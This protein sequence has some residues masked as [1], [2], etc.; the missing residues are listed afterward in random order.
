MEI[1]TINPIGLRCRILAVF[2]KR[3][4]FF[5]NKRYTWIREQSQYRRIEF[6]PFNTSMNDNDEKRISQL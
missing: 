6:K 5:L 3:I 1:K 2:Y 4:F